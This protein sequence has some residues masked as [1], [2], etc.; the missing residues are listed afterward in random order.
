MTPHP[1][2]E[3]VRRARWRQYP[4]LAAL[5][6]TRMVKAPSRVGGRLGGVGRAG[7]WLWCWTLAL[8][9]LAGFGGFTLRGRRAVVTAWVLED[10]W[11]GLVR[12]SP[13]L[14]AMAVAP[15]IVLMSTPVWL[16]V[17]FAG[18]VVV[19]LSANL[20]RAR[21]LGPLRRSRPPGAVLVAALASA[22]PG[23][24]KVVL[25]HVCRWAAD[26]GRSVCLEAT[27]HPRLVAYYREQGFEEGQAVRVGRRS[28]V[29]MERKPSQSE[30]AG[31]GPD[32][33]TE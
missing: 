1:E 19:G 9:T 5:V 31:A 27:G 24:G 8:V 6:A 11:R 29:Y 30:P 17:V 26:E 32:R 21:R 15:A 13:L 12:A 28:T 4:A 22:E 10:S 33:T 16:T 2:H 23:A 7:S 20:H 25:G 3:V 14:A 18:A